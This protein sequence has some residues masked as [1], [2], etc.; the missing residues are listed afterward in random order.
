MCQTNWNNGC[1]NGCNSGCFQNSWDFVP[2]A[3]PNVS[4]VQGPPGPQG[5]QGAPGVQGPAGPQGLTG[6]QG[7]RGLTGVQG[8]QGIQGVQGPQGPGIAAAPGFYTGVTTSETVAAGAPFSFATTAI[9]SANVLHPNAT[10]FVIQQA[11]VYSFDYFVSAL[12]GTGTSAIALSVNGTIMPN[13]S[14]ATTST[15]N[16]TLHGF[17]V[18]S[19]SAG[20]IVRVVNAGAAPIVTTAGANANTR[21]AITRLS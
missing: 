21:L 4:I 9:A 17:S 18:L 5:P 14:V 1:N 20:D 3:S 15:A 13:T 8:P 2:T 19:L 6:A 12:S 16:F 7:P 10:D 11:G